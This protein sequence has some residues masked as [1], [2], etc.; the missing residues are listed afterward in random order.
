MA[1]LSSQLIAEA[2]AHAQSDSL[3]DLRERC[4]GGTFRMTY[5]HASEILKKNSKLILLRNKNTLPKSVP[6]SC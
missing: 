2:T 3:E 5:V 1:S 4:A 6:V